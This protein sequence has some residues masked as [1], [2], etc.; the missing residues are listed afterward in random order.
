MLKGKILIIS[1]VVIVVIVVLIFISKSSPPI[2]EEKFVHLYIQLSLAHEK[3]KYDPPELEKEKNRILE[4]SQVTT[5]DVDKFI[6]A[7]KKRPEKWVKL[8]EKINQE[9]ER[10]KR[11]GS[12]S[13]P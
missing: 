3:Y 12:F 4:K 2:P 13:P 11:E 5:E 7:Y 1:S 6:K 8:W 9:L 10:L